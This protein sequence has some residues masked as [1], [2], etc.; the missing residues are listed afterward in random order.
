MRT[1]IGSSVAGPGADGWELFPSRSV[2]MWMPTRNDLYATE[3]RILLIESPSDPSPL[4]VRVH[5]HLTPAFRRSPVPVVP[6]VNGNLSARTGRRTKDITLEFF[7]GFLPLRFVSR[8][9]MDARHRPGSV[10]WDRCFLYVCDI[11][12][13]NTKP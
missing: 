11:K 5:H 4:F 1:G 8:V 2:S 7:V 6:V 13:S 12:A 10:W 3:H 9:F